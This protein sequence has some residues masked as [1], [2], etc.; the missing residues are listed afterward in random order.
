MFK[1]AIVV[2]AKGHL[3]GRLASYVAK[4]LLSGTHPLTQASRSSSSVVNP[5]TSVVNSSDTRFAS[6]NS[7]ASAS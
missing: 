6:Q 2:D 4:Q 5:S 3:M 1:K 7:S